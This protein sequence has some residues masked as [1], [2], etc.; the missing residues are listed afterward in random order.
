[1][2]KTT[3]TLLSMILGVTLYA[4]DFS[5]LQVGFQTPPP[6]AR[7]QVW[8]HWMNG[9]IT[10]DGIRK[11]IEWMDR[12]GIA[13]FHVFDAG[14][15]TPQV[16]P[17]R[18]VYMTGPWKEA[19][20]YAVEIG[21]EHGMEINIATSPGWSAT[22]GPW[23]KPED[24]MKRLTWRE[25]RVEGGKKIKAE[26]PE[27][28][29]TTGKF[30][31]A[32]LGSNVMDATSTLM[33]KTQHYRDIA[34]IAVRMLP[35][36]R[37]LSE[38][39]AVISSS[40][41]NFSLEKMTDGSMSSICRLPADKETGYGWIQYEFP[42]PQTIAAVSVSDGRIRDYWNDDEPT[43]TSVLE[44]SQ[45]GMSFTEVVK[46]PSGSACL[47]TVSFPPVQ[48]RF[49]RLKV[50]NPLP[51]LSMAAY[52]A[53]TQA[54]KYS[55][56][57]E[58]NLFPTA[59]I[60]H[61]EEKA[62]FASPHD[63]HAYRT[64]AKG[65]FPTEVLDLT[66]FVH[67][68]ILEWDVPEGNW[69]V[70]RFGHALTG[71]L[72]HPAPREAT[73]HEVDKLDPVAYERYFRQYLD[74]YQEALGG[75]LRGLD[76]LMM[77]S[78]EA[79]QQTWTPAMRE[80]FLSRRGYDLLPWLPVLAGEILE[81]A[82]RSEQ[83]LLDWRKT[84]SE[85]YAENYD[86]VSGL[87][88]EYGLK[89][90]YTESH[91][92]GRV[93]VVD[94]M[95][96][97]RLSEIPMSACWIPTPGAGSTLE[98]SRADIKESASVAHLWGQN[99]VAGESLTTSGMGGK[100]WSYDPRS[101]K[102]IADD[103][104][105]HGL[106]RF[107]IHESAH[108]PVD[109][110]QPGIGLMVF[111]QWFNRHETWAEEARA[112]TDYL[113]RSSYLLQQGQAVA[114]VLIY[115]GE[116]T[117]VT[118]EYGLGLP[119][120]VPAGY[121]Y[122]FINP[123]GLR[124]LLSVKGG[125][126]C[127]PSGMSYKVLCVD[128]DPTWMSGDMKARIE[129]LKHQGAVV[130]TPD[131]LASA[132]EKTAPDAILPADIRFVHRHTDDAEIYWINKPS[133][134]D[135]RV[136][137]SFRVK[138][139]KPRVW[140]PETGLCEEVSYRQK[141]GRTLVTLNLVPN[142]AVFVVFSGKGSRRQVLYDRAETVVKQLDGPW[143]VS[144]Q[145]GRGAPDTTV[146]DTLASWT[147]AQDF[148]IRHFSGTAT[149][150]QTFTAQSG[151]KTILDLGEVKNLAHIYLNGHDLGTR[152]KEPWTVDVTEALKDG[153]N[154]LVIEV[155]NLWPNRIIGDLQSDCPAQITYTHMQFFRPDSPLL[156]SG[157][158]GPVKLIRYE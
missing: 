148:S 23:V 49:F 106:N 6:E 24:A 16:V 29:T 127:S 119:D 51:D 156:P 58:F 55:K 146:F 138:G 121:S 120:Y 27:P 74:T 22:G 28:Y 53:S 111:G 95:D 36:D 89:G 40:G 129:S 8:W 35:Q 33:K 64:E 139:L 131:Q 118:A 128:A 65:D 93:Y 102:T 19:F 56:I 12:A 38:L 31:D 1:M 7:P 54:P 15:N 67:D 155:T 87:A 108:Q 98:M 152:W 71:K 57:A 46:I 113:A 105:A 79:E 112:W 62:G 90:R 32:E 17:E 10:R 145:A 76:Y 137:L 50:A 99:L 103:E 86:R 44:C 96:V 63:L 147:T 4:Q 68:G 157:L 153:E 130:C 43:W 69:K 66:D 123:T 70:F 126:L 133:D 136:E 141:G 140:H 107:I 117:N 158:F 39:G 85:L 21:K 20:R 3:L 77:D 110:L 13:G 34:V 109:S 45:D 47:Q 116:D 125:R 2:R 144:F 91:E 115:Y 26:L 124:E 132:L 72:N 25:M 75:T 83:F 88:R 30:Q 149:Y 100:A 37:T 81:S 82:A 14:L 78:Y 11:D 134:D 143:S 151:V 92:N 42:A 97:K 52:G 94:G 73:G 80:E 122:D 18:L 48:A 84:I 104:M 9:N 154:E 114:D 60:H 41:G 101:L 61:A 135:R 142:D 59:R 5:A 150:S